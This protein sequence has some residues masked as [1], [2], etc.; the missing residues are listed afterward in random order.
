VG[1]LNDKKQRILKEAAKILSV[2]APRL[3][4]AGKERKKV[5][6]ARGGVDLKDAI[7]ENGVFDN[8]WIFPF[9]KLLT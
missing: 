6:D 5:L 4:S 3:D 7:K 1:G 2:L 8:P 9:C